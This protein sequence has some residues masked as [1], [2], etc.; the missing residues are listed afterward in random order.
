MA[1]HAEA[2]DVEIEVLVGDGRSALRVIDDGVGP[3]GPEAPGATAC[4]TSR[5][6]A[7]RHGGTMH[8]EA[9]DGG[10]GCVLEWRVPLTERT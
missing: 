2:T 3:P 6:R 10:P 5:A 1:R 4:A 7:E 8:F 9:R